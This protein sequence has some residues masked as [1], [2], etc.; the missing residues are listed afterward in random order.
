MTHRP[1]WR[2]QILAVALA[3]GMVAALLLSLNGFWRQRFG[4]DLLWGLAAVAGLLAWIGWH[5]PGALLAAI[6]SAAAAAL[7][8]MPLDALL[9]NRYGYDGLGP[10]AFTVNRL[11]LQLGNWLGEVRSGQFV[12]MAPEVAAFFLVL[13]A[14][15]AGFS[16]IWE[17]LT[18]GDT[19][20]SLV[21][22]VALFGL[23]WALFWDKAEPYLIAY[24]AC[25]LTLWALAHAAH[26]SLRWAAEGRRAFQSPNWLAGMGAAVLVTVSAM[27]LPAHFRPVDLGYTADRLRDA[28]PALQKL[29]G[30]LAG[31]AAARFNLKLVGFGGDASVLGGPVRLTRGTALRLETG[32][33]IQESWYLRG[34]VRTEYTG[35]GWALPPDPSVAAG[36]NRLP[37]T[38]NTGAGTARVRQAT[39]VPLGLET[40]TLFHLLEPTQFTDLTEWRFDTEGNLVAGTV[41][42]TGDAYTFVSR[43]PVPSA[44]EARALGRPLDAAELARWE[45]H[46][47]LPDS[48]EMK[49]VAGLARSVTAGLTHPMDQALAIEAFLRRQYPYDLSP[50]PPRRSSDFVHDFLFRTRRGYCVYHSTAMAAMLR[51][52]GIP[53]RWVEGFVVPPTGTPTAEVAHNQAHAWVEAWIQGYGWV[54]FDPTPRADFPTIDR[55]YVPPPVTAGPS[56][57]GADQ[58]EPPPVPGRRDLLEGDPFAG[59]GGGDDSGGSGRTWPWL[60]GAAGAAL[61]ALL[62]WAWWRWRDPGTSADPAVAVQQAYEQSAELLGYF[63]FAPLPGM[64]A[65]EFTRALAAQWPELAE[66]IAPVA[67]AYQ[68]ARYGPPG[69]TLP[70]EARARAR[71]LRRQVWLLLQRRFGRTY[72]R[73]RLLWARRPHS[74]MLPAAVR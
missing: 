5:R 19:F 61:L 60:G 8:T 27:V 46:L 39:V 32:E 63:G 49:Q 17:A 56:G 64:T 37:A 22:G 21:F 33:P 67:E 70:P 31:S 12:T 34:T 20:W 48:S 16:I 9:Y 50:P 68:A 53:S 24:I 11:L 62:G 54:T 23:Q 71:R 40:D 58:P 41:R 14:L 43:Y 18:R 51:T 45:A 3:A 29:R 6:L 55:S 2:L 52:L 36:P 73:W 66:A 59:G 42:R 38:V 30:G 10:A 25:G 15:L 57:S 65:A 7:A 28:F 69:L 74:R 1:A 4:A 26:R 35:T 44:A 13:V 72:C 47:Q